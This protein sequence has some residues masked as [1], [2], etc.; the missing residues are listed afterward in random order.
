[1]LE[2]LAEAGGLALATTHLGALKRFASDCPGV[3]NGS[4]RFDPATEQPLYLLDKGLPGQ[5]R[6][7]EMAHR[8]GLPQPLLDRAAALVGTD[9][10]DVQALLSELET[11]RARVE[12]EK[13]A[14]ARESA[15][16]REAREKYEDRLRRLTGEYAG[17]KSRG[18]REGQ[19]V[20]DRARELLREAEEAA[21]EMGRQRAAEETAAGRRRAAEVRQRID[22]VRE[23]TDETGRRE[24]APGRPVTPVE[25][26]AG[27][28]FWAAPLQTWV[29]VLQPPGAGDKVR[30]ERNGVGVELPVTALRTGSEPAAP[31][32]PARGRALAELPADEEGPRRAGASFALPEAVRGEVDLR[33]LTAEEALE[34]L[35]G[36][37]DGATLGGLIEVRI[38]HGKGT[39]VLRQAVRQWLSG[40]TEVVSHRLGETWEGGT[41]VTVARLE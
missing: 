39:G 28:R 26:K 15:A 17:L 18:L 14:L 2:R 37:L 1:V 10:R 8:L 22:V 4:M 5:S 36:Y 13:Q 9:E 29:T 7:V 35:E 16:V 25:I 34:R 24:S 23:K 6:A 20:L 30:V 32:V 41:G 12:E 38:I 11:A 40:R 3:V 31:P 19:R 27:G 21:A 33:G